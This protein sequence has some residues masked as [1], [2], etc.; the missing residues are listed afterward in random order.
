MDGIIIVLIIFGG[1]GL[2]VTGYK[3][4]KDWNHKKE[5]EK[6]KWDDWENL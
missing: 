4:Y 5:L 3:I 6:Y 1:I 2:I